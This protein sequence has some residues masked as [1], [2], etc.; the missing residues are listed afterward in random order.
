MD[1]IRLKLTKRSVEALK[2]PADDSYIAW[3]TEAHLYGVRVA[4]SGR[5][6]YGFQPP[7][8]G[9]LGLGHHGVITPEQGRARARELLAKATLGEAI[10]SRRNK[11]KVMAGDTGPQTLLGLWQWHERN[12]QP[13]LSVKTLVAYRSLWRCHLARL[14]SKPLAEITAPLVQDWHRSVSRAAG[15]TAGN[16]A[17]VLLKLLLGYA[18]REHKLAG[19][20]AR[21]VRRNKTHDRD[22]VLEPAE[23]ERVLEILHPSEALVDKAL[24]FLLLT[25]SRRGEVQLMRWADVDLEGGTWKKPAE[26]VKTNRAQLLPLNSAALEL[27]RGL[28]RG[29]P[30]AS[31]FELDRH[32]NALHRRWAVLRKQAGVLDARIHD[33]RRTCATVLLAAGVDLVHV[34]GLLGHSQLSTTQIYARVRQEQLR[35]ASE[36]GAAVLAFRRPA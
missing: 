32:G 33:L 8:R 16:R 5:K 20:A 23:L 11:P 14:A 24:L 13:D 30:S 7:G 31:V 27:L 9:F 25:G 18:E 34:S 22:R 35:A 29:T 21:G 3:D 17:L 36:K 10:P 1:T 26:T 2:P 15:K 19:N 6:T 28:P 4:S 12:I